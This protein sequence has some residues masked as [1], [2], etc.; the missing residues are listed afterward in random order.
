MT[1]CKKHIAID[2]G[3]S[4]VRVM[5]IE[6]DS[7][8][9]ELYRF[10]H[11]PVLIGGT[12][13]WDV[14]NLFLH[15]KTA[16]DTTLE[17]QKISSIGICSW[18][19]DYG[20]IRSDG[21]LLDLPISYRDSRTEKIIDGSDLKRAFFKSGIYP[22][23][24][25]T[26]FQL[27]ADLKE[28]RYNIDD[29]LKFV[30]MADLFAYYLTGKIFVEQT[31][32]STTGLLSL[33]GKSWDYNLIKEV[34]LKKEM[35]PELIYPGELIGKYKGVDVL[36]VC[37]HDTA[38]AIHAMDGLDEETVF[39]SSGSWVLIGVVLKEPLVTEEVFNS[40]FT[41]ER[42]YGNSVLLLNNMNGL[43][44]IQRLVAENKELTYKEIDK[45]IG[46]AK[47]L[48][49][50]NL[51][52]LDK[53]SDMKTQM[54]N[55]LGLVDADL[56]DLAKTFYDALIQ[57]IRDKIHLIEKL[58]CRTITK[59][60]LTGGLSKVP[61]VM[62]KLQNLYPNGIKISSNEGAIVGIAKILNSHH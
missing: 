56:F 1:G 48:G 27:M 2:F 4:S 7:T 51:M 10:S 47:N 53:P 35:F 15:V 59:I 44:V 28:G 30:M 6:S 43:F 33:T 23:K 19:V 62:E 8:F 36:A 32:A 39:I 21:T 22:L 14:E 55:Q 38:S 54:L 45:N 18:G 49:R 5:L 52:A 24:I 17:K 41:N 57:E 12:Y 60:T 25:N 34:G 37:S 11:S 9:Q 3:S 26:N 46:S 58:T 29:N 61:Y 13:R 42:G 16:I 40:N 20:L 50:L 31:N